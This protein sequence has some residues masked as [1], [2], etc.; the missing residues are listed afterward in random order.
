MQ[1]QVREKSWIH[2][3]GFVDLVVHGKTIQE[4]VDTGATHNFMMT[5]LAK[6]VGLNIFPSNVEI[7]AV[8]SRARVAGLA[9]EVLVQIK[10]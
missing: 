10:Y 5:R 8:N 7:K 4:L 2:S 9:H 3:L 6:E 1:S